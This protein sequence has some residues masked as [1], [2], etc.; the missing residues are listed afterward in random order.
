MNMQFKIESGD[1]KESVGN[2]FHIKQNRK[3]FLLYYNLV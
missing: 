1:H 2:E 3:Y